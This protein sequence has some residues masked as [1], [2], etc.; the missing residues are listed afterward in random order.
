MVI[1]RHPSRAQS[2]VSAASWQCL[3]CLCCTTEHDTEV[4]GSLNLIKIAEV[5]GL[6]LGTKMYRCGHRVGRAKL[7]VSRVSW[8]QSGAACAKQMC[9]STCWE[10]A[11]LVK[12]LYVCKTEEAVS[13]S[14]GIVSASLTVLSLGWFRQ[15]LY[16]TDKGL[17]LS[18]KSQP[19]CLSRAHHGFTC[20]R[21]N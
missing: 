21:N 9:S 7:P 17:N 1:Y 16:R 2:W 15:E 5:Q 4:T 11:C 8:R 19:K 14:L 3:G 18:I 10:L 13:D 20:R 12:H 6:L